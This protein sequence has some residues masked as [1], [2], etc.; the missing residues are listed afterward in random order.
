MLPMKCKNLSSLSRFKSTEL[1]KRP[2]CLCRTSVEFHTSKFGRTY[3]RLIFASR[4]PAL[5]L[6][7]VDTILDNG[8][9]P[10]SFSR[11][12]E[13]AQDDPE[14]F[15]LRPPSSRDSSTQH[16]QNPV[17]RPNLR[18]SIPPSALDTSPSFT[19]QHH[20]ILPLP[21]RT[22][23]SVANV[24]ESFSLSSMS[25]PPY[26]TTPYFATSHSAEAF[27]AIS[28]SLAAPFH[29]HTPQ[30]WPP[31]D[32]YP[33]SLTPMSLSPAHVLPAAYPSGAQ[34]VFSTGLVSASYDQAILSDDVEEYDHLQA[35]IAELQD[36]YECLAPTTPITGDH[37]AQTCNQTDPFDE[38]LLEENDRLRSE[39]TN[40]HES[41]QDERERADDL[42]RRLG[43]NEGS[44]SAEKS[45]WQEEKDEPQGEIE[46]LERRLE[47]RALR[48]T[49]GFDKHDTT[50]RTNA[51]PVQ[52]IHNDTSST[53][54]E[55]VASTVLGKHYR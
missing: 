51:G 37:L 27:A 4:F 2:T 35:E 13:E 28:A 31:Y 33:H 44:Y 40:L 47:S 5:A 49:A 16:S 12:K 23:H 29:Y 19:E 15:S 8:Q 17:S 6:E 43:F 1:T 18:L 14:G 26:S 39:N 54:T 38:N 9:G 22:A 21:L 20:H 7:D 24:G 53:S 50:P 34:C 45:M 55:S 48:S 32:S 42:T 25:P 41:L 30:D 46:R 52:M 11:C 3:V 10:L 36:S